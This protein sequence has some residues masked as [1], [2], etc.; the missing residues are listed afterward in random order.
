MEHLLREKEWIDHVEKIIDEIW[1][2]VIVDREQ[3][4]KYIGLYQVSNLGRVRSLDRMGK[5]GKLRK[6]KMII[7]GESK[8]GYRQVALCKDGKMKQ[9]KVHRLVLLAFDYGNYFVGA[10]V[11]HKDENPRNN[12]LDNIEWCS[13]KYNCNY[14]SHRKNISK[15]N[16]G[17]KL[18]TAQCAAIRERM[19]GKYVGELNP[20]SRTHTNGKRI[21]CLNNHTVYPSI[22]H[23]AIIL[24]LDHSTITKICKGIK[25]SLHGY[26]FMYYPG[27][28]KQVNTEITAE[29]KEPAAS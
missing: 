20:A 21:I 18:T 16:R 5:R 15:A 1:K 9:Y 2:D 14:G 24:N 7:P 11:N 27:Y 19:M 13:S 12:S 10:E 17:R 29:R 6:G 8:Q 3:E 4:E 22:R 28:L 25:K 23:A 26:K